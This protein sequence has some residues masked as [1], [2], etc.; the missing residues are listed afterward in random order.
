M[1][2]IAGGAEV[3]AIPE[4]ETTPE[5]IAHEL[6]AAYERGKPHAIAV[7]AEGAR[8]N[9]TA[10][11]AF[12]DE[13]HSRIV[14]DL[15]TTTLGHVQRGGQPSAYDRLLATRV[16]A[17]AG[18]TLARGEHGVLMGMRGGHLTATP[19]CDVADRQKSL[20]PEKIRLANVLA[21]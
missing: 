2:A 11:T 14:F 20:D 4:V 15:R 3:V 19:L 17:G 10:L 9:A 6:W 12:S 16:G 18:A 5:I 13:H 21:R 7:V 8:H 1:A